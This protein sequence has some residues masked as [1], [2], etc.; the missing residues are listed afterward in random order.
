MKTLKQITLALVLL[1]SF[2][3]FATTACIEDTETIKEELIAKMAEDDTVIAVYTNVST[4]TFVESLKKEF[5][6]SG[7][8]YDLDYD[9]F[10]E[11][12]NADLKI[13]EAKY[14]ELYKLSKEDQNDVLAKVTN[15][16]NK[17]KDT[18]KC[19][20]IAS[21]GI[22]GTCGTYF[23]SWVIKKYGACMV[24]GGSIV[25]AEL[26]LSGGSATG[27]IPEEMSGVNSVCL[28]FALRLNGQAAKDLAL[29]MFAGLVGE[30]LACGTTYFLS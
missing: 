13:I 3:T 19:V 15:R 21:A 7:E 18:L 1:V 22:A 29:C 14:P 20:I 6:L 26:I 23:G 25:I 16:S 9:K 2:N 11:G 24:A 4:V 28:R 10:N 30:V 17:L 12:L 8:E 27:L 5:N